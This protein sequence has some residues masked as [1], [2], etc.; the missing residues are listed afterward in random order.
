MIFYVKKIGML[1][2]AVHLNDK[3]DEEKKFLLYIS[4]SQT[5]SNTISSKNI[6]IIFLTESENTCLV[7]HCVSVGLMK[8]MTIP[9]INHKV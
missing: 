2:L 1:W 7:R 8:N 9:H 5:S 4:S 6:K 3:D